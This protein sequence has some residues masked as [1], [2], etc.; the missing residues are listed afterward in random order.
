MANDMGLRLLSVCAVV[1][2]VLFLTSGGE[3]AMK[4]K[5]SDWEMTTGTYPPVSRD[6]PFVAVVGLS[7][8]G[9]S[10]LAAVLDTLNLTQMHA[11]PTIEHHIE[12]WCVMICCLSLLDEIP[13]YR[14]VFGVI[15]SRVRS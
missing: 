11:L 13:R 7:R 14:L 6:K 3:T 2:A 10:S 4:T 12:F 1:F 9:T 15:Y 5:P 8:T